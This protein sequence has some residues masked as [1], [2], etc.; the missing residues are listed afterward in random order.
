MKWININKDFPAEGSIVFV[1]IENIDGEMLCKFKNDSFG[2]GDL[3]FNVTKW[4]YAIPNVSTNLK[5]PY[6]N[7]Q[8]TSHT[9]DRKDAY[10]LELLENLGT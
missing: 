10:S 7:L 4:R 6:Y 9:E 8:S 1:R 3:D 2:L 5:S